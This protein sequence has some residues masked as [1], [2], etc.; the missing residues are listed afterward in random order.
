[1][2]FGSYGPRAAPGRPDRPADGQ[3]GE[4]ALPPGRG[5][6]RR[7]HAGRL[8][9]RRPR[10]CSRRR[11]PGGRARATSL[12]CRRI[13]QKDKSGSTSQFF[14]WEGML[15]PNPNGPHPDQPLHRRA[16]LRPLRL[17][18]QDLRLAV[19]APLQRALGRCG[20]TCATRATR[21]TTSACTATRSPLP[22]GW[23]GD[24]VNKRLL[25]RFADV[26]EH[27]GRMADGRPARAG[28]LRHRRAAAQAAG[29][30][31]L[32]CATARTRTRSST[33]RPTSAAAC[34]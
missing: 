25:G 4:L 17:R 16:R 30:R 24:P 27:P 28:R 5:R 13:W 3:D 20:R 8:R 31:G 12:T 18:A 33:R 1:M 2:Q 11:S 34:R 14:P 19:R 32:R 6:P 7:G 15:L 22:G 9:A 10:S 23:A 29:R 21:S 26:D